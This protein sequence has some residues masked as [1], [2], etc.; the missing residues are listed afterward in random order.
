MALT[1]NGSNN[2]IAGLAVGGLP[3]GSVDTD[4]IAASAVTA[5]KANISGSIVN[6]AQVVKYDTAS[7]GVAQGAYSEALL[8]LS[9]AAASS[10]NK[11]LIIANC[12]V[13]TQT[14]ANVWST[15]FINGS[16]SAFRGNADGN[17]QRVSSGSPES[18]SATN[19]DE[20]TIVYLLSSPSTSSVAYDVRAG[21]AQDATQNCYINR[22]H[23]DGDTS[24]TGRMASS[25]TILEVA[26]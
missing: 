22:A 12:C 17:R 23:S 25:I 2:T 19:V 9:Y 10:S 18:G 11:L 16:A 1:L 3:D 15:L 26:A 24:Y 21:H 4:M 13:G 8:S 20:N 7:T 6:V 5:A 14:A